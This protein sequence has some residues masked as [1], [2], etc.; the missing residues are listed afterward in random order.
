MDQLRI[1]L[2]WLRRYHF[3]VLCVIVAAVAIGCWYSAAGALT[4]QFKANQAKIKREFDSQ[5]QL[6][7]QQFH[8]NDQVNQRQQEEI[9]KQ[10]DSVLRT[11]DT[12]YK[13]QEEEALQWPKEFDETFLKG[14]ESLKFEDEISYSLREQYFNYIKNHFPELPKIVG[15]KPITDADRGGRVGRGMMPSE[16][17]GPEVP[18]QRGTQDGSDDDSNYLVEWLDQAHVRDELQWPQLPSSLEIWKVQED[19]W[20]YQTLLQ[21]VADTNQGA[22]RRSNVPV[23]VIESLEVGTVAAQG[24]NT[25]GRILNPSTGTNPS[26]GGMGGFPGGG[27]EAPGASFSEGPP[28]GTWG[29]AGM[30]GGGDD[31]GDTRVRL[32]SNRYLDKNG[33]PIAVAGPSTGPNEFGVE[34]KRLPIRME[35][36]MDERAIPRLIANCTNQPLQVEVQQ[37]R[38]NPADVSSSRTRR[39]GFNSSGGAQTF[40]AQPNMATVV[41]Q[42][43]IYIINEPNTSSLQVAEM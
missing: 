34:F 18:G 13:R 15:A 33:Q 25:T 26:M 24:S 39:A 2:T 41:I 22:D 8:A 6:A 40:D 14:V 43:I 20:V 31:G 7:R 27:G 9:K 3:W 16:R 12:L 5:A 11:W 28:P 32:L 10:A 19:L 35:L 1:A 37:V 21:I 17:F 4:Q 42:G 36:Q 38:I 30:M 23:R 29:G